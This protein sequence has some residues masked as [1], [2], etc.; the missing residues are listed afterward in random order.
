MIEVYKRCPE[1]KDASQV[2]GRLEGLVRITN[3]RTGDQL[4][5]GLS[6]RWKSAT[7][8]ADEL[9]RQAGDWFTELQK[10]F[11]LPPDA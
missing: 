9:R 5:V 11:S 4:N 8:T 2:P 7:S 3:A 10:E 1:V 6:D